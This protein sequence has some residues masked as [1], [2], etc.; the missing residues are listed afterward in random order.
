MTPGHSIETRV[1]GA[2]ESWLRWL[3]RW[4]PASHRTRA[5][6]CP[7]CFGSPLVAAASLDGDVPHA[8]QHALVMRLNTI[9]EQAVD[10]YTERNLPLL[11][12]ELRDAD[13]RK[14]SSPYRPGEGL[15]PE[16]QGLE[17][18]PEPIAGQ[19]FLFTLAELADDVAAPHR[20]P[21]PEPL[22]DEAKD[23]LR[24]EVALAD[25]EATRIGMSVCLELTAYRPRIRSAIEHLVE[26]QIEALLQELTRS[27][28]APGGML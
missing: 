24:R 17:L 23:A 6:V 22:S 13:A 11:W 20:L 7:R 21:D 25:D 9:I 15:A 3:P 27:L 18:D 10:A 14:R 5:R 8:V 19:P 2:V 1:R 26:P 28:D 4:E 12:R 16:F